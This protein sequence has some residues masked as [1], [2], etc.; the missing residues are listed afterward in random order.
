MALTVADALRELPVLALAQV[1]AGQGGLQRELRWAH[2]VDIPEVAPWVRGGDLLLTTAYALQDKPEA[3]M[4]LLRTL[5]E[6][7]LSGI[8]VAIGRYF[9]TI[10]EPMIRL[11]NEMDFPIITLPW[12]VPFVDVT[13][14]IHEQILSQQYALVERSLY[15]H[16]VLT[17]LVLQGKGLTDLVQALAAILGLSVTI[18]DPTLHL[19]AHA[20]AGPEDEMRQRSIA[21]G[22]TP[23]ALKAHLMAQGL[24]DRLR[25]DPRPQR[26]GPV[27][28]LGA[29][30]ERVVAPISVGAQLYGYI[31]IIAT[32]RPLSEFDFLAIERG[33]TLAALIMTRQQAIYEAEQRLVASQ[34]DRLLDPAAPSSPERAETLQRLGLASGYQTL[35]IQPVGDNPATLNQLSPLVSRLVHRTGLEGTVV[36]RAG[37]LVV[38]LGTQDGGC[39]RQV[40]Q[41]L[42]EMAQEED[43]ALVVGLSSCAADPSASRRCYEEAVEAAR[44]GAALYDGRPSAWAHADLGVL[45]WL[46]RVPDEVRSVDR[47]T[48]LVQAIAAHDEEQGSD[49][50]HTLETYLDRQGNAQAAAAALFIHR[51]T[52][53]QRLERI[54]E[55]WNVDLETPYA[56]LNL[57]VAIK[58]WRL[59]GQE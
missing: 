34:L 16:K 36:E 12:E 33:A 31:W 47:Y 13:R 35:A 51:N 37:R 10:P 14:A 30:L 7:G 25:R 32:G 39:G 44:V 42:A 19:L 8:L 45:H 53:R 11:A 41:S 23:E 43:L 29:T 3:Q 24:F 22:R 26:L 40:A 20:S 2:V 21:E 18:E 1:V 59:Q 15:I 52:L 56:L 58:A 6:K 55:T 5:V 48:R 17:E 49:Y 38:L 27:P 57:A 54:T 46:Q 9:H 28:E 50:L 4:A